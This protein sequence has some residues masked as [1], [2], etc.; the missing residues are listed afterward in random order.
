MYVYMSVNGMYLFI[1]FLSSAYTHILTY[2]G[3]V[4]YEAIHSP[5]Y[6]V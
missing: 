5:I 1:L 2:G 3:G 6:N 4:W